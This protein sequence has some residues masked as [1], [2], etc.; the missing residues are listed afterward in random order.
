MDSQA[1]DAQESTARGSRSDWLAS[2]LNAPRLS[3]LSAIVFSGSITLGQL[4]AA[5][6]VRPPTMTR[7]VHALAAQGLVVKS[8]DPG[9][10]RT[11]RI[12]ATMK[13][14]RVLLAG[15]NRRIDALAEAIHRLS[16]SD[17][18]ALRRALP[19]LEKLPPLTR[20]GCIH[21]PGFVETSPRG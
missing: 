13:G 4:A 5:E 9:D 12:S 6:Q 14:K 2:S 1:P 8:G 17:Q 18:A 10:R 19:I 21:S 3:A 7:I 11:I 16:P 15:R 20:A